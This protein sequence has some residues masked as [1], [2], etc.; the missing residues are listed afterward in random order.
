M[1]QM[2]SYK[3]PCGSKNYYPEKIDYFTRKGKF[4]LFPTY[5]SKRK[6]G[7]IIS[8]KQ[9]GVDIIVQGPPEAIVNLYQSIS[10]EENEI[11]D[12]NGVFVYKEAQTKEEFEQVFEKFVSHSDHI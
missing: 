7:Y 3:L 8:P 5:S 2:S 10:L 1:P 9:K 11:R 4:I 12:E 6:I